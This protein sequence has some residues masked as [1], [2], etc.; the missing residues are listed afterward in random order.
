MIQSKFEETTKLFWN[1]YNYKIVLVTTYATIFRNSRIHKINDS[2]QVIRKRLAASSNDDP[3]AVLAPEL[4]LISLINSMSDY[5]IRSSYP[6]V[7]IYTNNLIDVNKLE[8][9]GEFYKSLKLLSKPKNANK[10]ILPNTI[11]SKNSDFKFKVIIGYSKSY[12]NN[13]AA[14]AVNND[15]IKITKH[16]LYKMKNNSYF[17]TAYF[18]V[19]DGKSLTMV[20]MFLGSNIRTVEELVT[21]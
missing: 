12:Y 13:F 3:D 8:K 19:K 17:S 1:E 21:E 9:Y 20:K 15:K 6:Y 16:L 4:E 5:K 2:L 10:H 11:I 7:S 14:W 18:Y